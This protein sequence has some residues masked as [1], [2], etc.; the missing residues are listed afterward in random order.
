MLRVWSSWES[1]G[2]PILGTLLHLPARYSTCAEVVQSTPCRPNM[3]CLLPLQ[4]FIL[5]WAL[6]II[7]TACRW[8]GEGHPAASLRGKSGILS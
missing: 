6:S 7:S 5:R 4:F 3:H 2:L 8:S 1:M